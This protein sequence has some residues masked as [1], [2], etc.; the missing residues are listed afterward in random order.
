MPEQ[1]KKAI[2]ELQNALKKLMANYAKLDHW[3]TFDTTEEG[4][5]IM[6]NK[7]KDLLVISVTDIQN[8]IDCQKVA[9]TFVK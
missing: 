1:G 8:Y 6:P 5:P 9:R 7:L 4:T 2:T 3:Y